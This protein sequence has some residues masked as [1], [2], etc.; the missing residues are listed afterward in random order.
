LLDGFE[1][2]EEG[3]AEKTGDIPFEHGYQFGSQV[4]QVSEP[5]RAKEDEDHENHIDHK[6]DDK[7]GGGDGGLFRA[8]YIGAYEF[9]VSV[10]EEPAF[11][12]FEDGDGDEKNSP[13]AIT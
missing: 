1:M 8:F 5:G 6:V 9:D 7:R 10:F 12:R 13:C 4:Q 11:G 2:R 3:H